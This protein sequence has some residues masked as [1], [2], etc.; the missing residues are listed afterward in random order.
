MIQ[1]KP[2]ARFI[3]NELVYK[4]I[5]RKKIAINFENIEVSIFPLETVIK[6]GH[7]NFIQ[8]NIGGAFDSVSFQVN[9][10]DLFRNKLIIGQIKID[11]LK[12]N[13]T[14]KKSKKTPSSNTTKNLKS[15]EKII[16]EL[17]FKISK[18]LISNSFIQ[19]NH[20]RGKF[21]NIEM[22]V[23]KKAIAVDLHAVDFQLKTN[24][25]WHKNIDSIKASATID[26]NKV[27]INL[28]NL[29]IGRGKVLS[30]GVFLI[31]NNSYN[32][33]IK[34]NLPLEE[35]QET[36]PSKKFN[37]VKRGN[38]KLDGSIKFQKTFNVYG[39][40]IIEDFESKHASFKKMTGSLA[41]SQE[42]IGL[43]NTHITTTHGTIKVEKEI[44]FNFIN[45]QHNLEGTHIDVNNVKTGTIFAF[46]GNK[47]KP[48][49]SFIT[50]DIIFRLQKR[51]LKFFIPNG[52]NL[53]K[54]NLTFD[55]FNILSFKKL[56]L[57]KT[58][59]EYNLQTKTFSMKSDILLDQ[60]LLKARG[61][62]NATHVDI[63]FKNSN[64]NFN[65]IKHI[66][67][68]RVKGKG[69]MDFK[70]LGPLGNA[71]IILT[72]KVKN[73]F[74]YKYSLGDSNIGITY[75]LKTKKLNIDRFQTTS[76]DIRASAKGNLD[77]SKEAKNNLDVEIDVDKIGY[78]SMYNIIQSHL[79]KFIPRIDGLNFISS[80]K[81]VLKTHFKK[82]IEVIKTDFNFTSITYLNEII[83]SAYFELF[84]DNKWVSIKNFNFKKGGGQAFG[85]L[86]YEIHKK[87]FEYDFQIKGIGL[88]SFVFYRSLQMGLT[89]KIDGQFYRSGSLKEFSTYTLIKLTDPMINEEAIPIPGLTI[90]GDQNNYSLTWNIFK[91]GIEGNAF[92]NFNA[93]G[94]PS[95]I[96]LNINLKNLN[97]IL[98]A[99]FE[100]NSRQDIQGTLRAKLN[101]S[102]SLNSPSKLNINFL[103][104][105]FDLNYGK[106]RIFLSG[107]KNQIN[108]LEGIIKYWDIQLIGNENKITSLGNGDLNNQFTI[109]NNYIFNPEI[110]KIFFRNL[111][112]AS[113][114]IEGETLFL[115]GKD[116][117]SI[118]SKVFGKNLV[119]S[120]KEP[121][122]AF[123]NINFEISSENRQIIINNIKGRYGRGEFDIRGNLE[124]NFPY[125]RPYIQGTFKNINYNFLTRSNVIASGRVNLLGEKPPY[126]LRGR[127]VINKAL[128]LDSITELTKEINNPYIDSKF[129]PQVKKRITNDLF[130]I[131]MDLNANNS[132]EIKTKMIDAILSSNISIQGPFE[133]LFF[134]GSASIIPNVSKISFKG[135]E[136]LLKNGKVEFRD[137][138]SKEPP[139]L[140]L[141]GS[142]S[143]DK[144]KVFLS[145]IGSTDNLEM[146]LRSEPSLNREDILSLITFG[147]TLE[148]SENLDEEQ[149]QFLTTMS[150][151]SFFIDQLQIGK[152]LSGKLGLRFIVTPELDDNN[153]N[154]IAKQSSGVSGTRKLKS[155]TKLTLESDIGERTSISISS[156]LGAENRRTQELKVDYNIN[157]ILSLQGIYEN[158]TRED[159]SQESNSFGGDIKFKWIFG[160]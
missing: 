153:E 141:E 7:L 144:Y 32:G 24:K 116:K 82:G 145:V 123:E 14:S 18:I 37:F 146:K 102:F 71:N 4:K 107:N 66:A 33:T 65:T 11:G 115:N 127:V 142:S 106:K 119:F 109:T 143:I 140:Q 62:I 137:F 74:V 149:K 121:F 8:E 38:L 3:Q 39:D 36:F 44:H 17:P 34:V 69:N 100:H 46:L 114:I 49:D 67:G 21:K 83:P 60:S 158:T 136:F 30:K 150:L 159:R 88:N 43:K 96:N 87:Y 28:F 93:N 25:K 63:G 56:N 108:I 35:L 19:S 75:G 16:S 126:S 40:V 70:V 50:G 12:S 59:F 54:P 101:S 112:N 29:R 95:Y 45:K 79:P 9:I 147:Y 48:F 91:E 15:I 89:G 53:T 156:S 92:F 22:T 152:D 85:Y 105:Q 148:T 110:L 78:V 2:F 118:L 68:V 31:R 94:E 76:L 97:Q 55:N 104:E 64:V 134:T 151:G 58:V 124:L 73:M 5:D 130:H 10:S 122:G 57:E 154:L 27:N 1:T 41:I 20:L 138:N 80:G 117:N 120:Y 72:G 61:S 129:L 42:T 155:L 51:T 111:E 86:N 125:P 77:F 113:G 157:K 133:D 139:F 131:D 26:R 52:L 47:L 6:N 98:S 23:N 90:Y 13:I 81:A 84:I 103:L 128:F 135:Q 99:L 160:D 132:I